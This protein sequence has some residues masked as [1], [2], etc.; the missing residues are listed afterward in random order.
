MARSFVIGDVHGHYAAL[1]HLLNLIAP[2]AEDRVILLGDLIDRGPASASVVTLVQ[3]EGYRTLLGNHEE[4]LI[5][6]LQSGVGSLAWNRWLAMGGSSTL[7][8]FGS[9]EC[10]LTYLP[11]L[12]TLPTHWNCGSHFLAH[13]G[14]DPRRPLYA[15]TS[16]EFCWSR[17]VFLAARRP[18]FPDK[19]IVVGHTPT[20][21]F[22]G[23]EPGQVLAGAGW[24]NIDTGIYLEQSGWLTALELT[25]DQIYQVHLAGERRILPL[26]EVQHCYVPGRWFQL[27][28]SLF[29][30]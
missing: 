30:P 12:Q 11:W 25:S 15:Q 5:R 8:S 14:L 17:E 27:T 22:P 13:A 29:A 1:C 16:R 28:H 2:T 26:A 9:L 4:Q 19:C 21:R 3:Q 23:V 7:H 24:L 20:C 18:Y 10:L 6:A